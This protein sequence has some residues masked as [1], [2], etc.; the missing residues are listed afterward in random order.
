L[1]IALDVMGGDHAPAA[2]VK[3]ALDAAPLL[4]AKLLLVGDEAKFKH[5]LP[6]ILPANIE[7]VHAS[8]SVEM[9]EK[10]LDAYRKKK[11][12]SL[13]VAARLVRDGDAHALVSAGITGAA[14]ATSLLQWRQIEGVHRPAIASHL[15]N[16]HGGF[17]LLDV[18][19]S[20]DVD[21][22]HIVEFAIMGRAYAQKLMGRQN[23]KVQ[24]LNIGEEEGKGNAFAKQAYT[25]LKRHAWFAGNVEGKD[26]FSSEVDVVVCDAFV[27]NIVLKSC[28]GL[29]ELIIDSIRSEVPTQWPGKLL[30]W[31]VKK[32]TLPLRKQMDYAEVGGSP[33]LGLNGLCMIC[34]GRSSPKA[35]RNALL[36]TERALDNGLVETIRRTVCDELGSTNE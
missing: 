18:G 3:G 5:L 32:V 27:G 9:D 10:P 13:M 4:K 19:A 36:T 8:Q 31:P 24:L 20:P 6:D 11:D 28:E 22:E 26:M 12:S 16:K 14:S 1:S 17:V 30:Y 35:I 25:L 21:P 7:L 23:P 2:I 15:P 29:A 33:L 34:H